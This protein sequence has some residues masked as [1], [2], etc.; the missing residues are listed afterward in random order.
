MDRMLLL[1]VTLKGRVL[2]SYG[3][4]KDVVRIGRD[5]DSDVLLDHPG[6]SRSHAEI[7]L[8]DGAFVLRDCGSSNKTFHN[9]RP[10]VCSELADGDRIQVGKYVLHVG[11]TPAEEWTPPHRYDYPTVRMGG[12]QVEPPPG[13]A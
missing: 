4:S 8:E 13:P 9:G 1:Q 12:L 2:K 11:V 10:C 7:E 6:I 5:P 3:L